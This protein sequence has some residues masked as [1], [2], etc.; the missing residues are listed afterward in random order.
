MTDCVALLKSGAAPSLPAPAD[1]VAL[2]IN[3]GASTV[4]RA[5]L[6]SSYKFIFSSGR[7]QSL[8]GAR[9]EPGMWD[10][11]EVRRKLRLR[12]ECE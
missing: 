2:A 10:A 5:T 1:V 9:R 7:M 8:H 11:M 3:L 12:V 4:T 6:L